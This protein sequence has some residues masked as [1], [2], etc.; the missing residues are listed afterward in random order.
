MNIFKLSK[1]STIYT[2][3]NLGLKKIL[4]INELFNSNILYI[5]QTYITN[6]Y[7]SR[8][9]K[10]YDKYKKGFNNKDD[11]MNKISTKKLDSIDFYDLC[12]SNKLIKPI[13]NKYN[14]YPLISVIL[15][16]YNKQKEIL[17][18]IR[19]IQNQSFKN[20]EIIIVD[21]YSKDESINIY[22]QLLKTDK[23][24][25]IF[26]H[27]KNMGVWR[28]RLDG[29]L[30]SRG[31]YI[32]NFDVGDLYADNLILEDSYDLITK[33]NL[34]SVRFSFK[35]ARDKKNIDNNYKIYKF[36]KKY[37]K[38]ILGNYIYNVENYIHGPI[39]NRLIKKSIILRSLDL[40][41]SHILN[42]Y[43]NLWEDR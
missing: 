2:K 41:D 10:F 35:I 24:I 32:I 29:L 42:A 6:K 25:R 3:N 18:S 40:I 37:T 1:I 39:W 12:N 14:Y 15:P 7:I 11:K 23:R 33:Y 9:K 43:K 16:S 20:I 5:N 26:F 4:K 21:D 17:K 38:I 30:Y 8:I 22:N 31:K 27:L 19:S 36:E 34:D 28:S 13:Y